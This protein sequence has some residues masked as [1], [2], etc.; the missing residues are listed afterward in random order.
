MKTGRGK[1]KNS[2]KNLTQCHFLMHCPKNEPTMKLIPNHLSH[3]M[4]PNAHI[5]TMDLPVAFLGREP[6][7]RQRAVF[8]KQ[9]VPPQF[10]SQVEG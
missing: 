1:P 4:H 2:E 5:K 9:P 3:S 8:G 10:C 7:Q 6:H